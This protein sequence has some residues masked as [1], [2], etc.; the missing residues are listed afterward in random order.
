MSGDG[1][2]GAQG[3][4]AGH[5]VA[6]AVLVG[7]L[8]G[9]QAGQETQQQGGYD[10]YAEDHGTLLPRFPVTR[11]GGGRRFIGSSA[12]ISVSATFPPMTAYGP[13]RSRGGS[14]SAGT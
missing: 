1:A 9:R 12:W 13:A 4:E 10:E 8:E 2:L 7:L 14:R 11:R 6:V 5:A 3:A